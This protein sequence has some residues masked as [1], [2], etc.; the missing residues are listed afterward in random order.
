MMMTMM[1]T[2]GAKVAIGRVKTVDIVTVVIAKCLD[3]VVD[4]TDVIRVVEHHKY[5][6]DYDLS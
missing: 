6:N 5:A 1:T 4:K 3:T 2:I